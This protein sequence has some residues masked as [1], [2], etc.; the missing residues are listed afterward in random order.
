MIA[1][2]ITINATP[3]QCFDVIS[4]FSHYPKFLDDLKKVTISKKKGNECLVTYHLMVV[5]EI[6]YT[7]RTTV[8]PK[9]MRI[10]WA[11]VE[12]DYMRDNHGFWEL[13]EI[14]KGQT[15]ATYHIDIQFGFLVPGF[16]TKMLTE[17]HLPK[18]LK[19][20]KE[21]IEAD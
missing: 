5:K 20:F 1:R 13:K 3:R 21:K 7:L 18:M 19:A 9:K 8:D 2:K 17:Q 16:V 4:D 14:K 6:V 15:V 10:E 12:G 11:F